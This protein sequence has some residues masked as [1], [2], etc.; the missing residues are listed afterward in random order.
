[1]SFAEILILKKFWQT[2]F[3]L[4]DFCMEN[5]IKSKQL[6]ES[7]DA[8]LRS[9][10]IL[11]LLSKYGEVIIK[12]SYAADLMIEGDIDIHVIGKDDFDKNKTLEIFNDI[13]RNS[14]FRSYFIHGDWDDVRK[15]NE[16][17]NGNYI[18]LKIWKAEEKW[19]F[20]IWLM[21]KEEY[22]KR[23]H[24]GISVA[25]LHLTDEQRKSI[26]LLKFYNREKKIGRTSQEIYKMVLED[27]I[28]TIE[29]F[30]AIHK[31]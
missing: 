4:A 13:Y 1:V 3:D 26:L 17:P 16:F 27:N 29:E 11:N 21:S 23:R 5:F 25:D 18:G 24:T 14:N 19:K 8:L 7:A 31:M 12:G 6:R 22:E 28:S 2:G 30:E 20:D 10:N 15:G 9:T